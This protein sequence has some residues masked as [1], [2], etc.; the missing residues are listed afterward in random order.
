MKDE[1]DV[2]QIIN[3]NEFKIFDSAL[4]QHNLITILQKGDSKRLTK[5][6]V[7]KRKNQTGT[8]LLQNILSGVDSE[9][10]YLIRANIFDSDLNYIRIPIDSS[11]NLKSDCIFT[12]ILS[13]SVSLGELVNINSG[14]DITISKITQ[15][16]LKKFQH[17]SLEKDE[18]VFVI[19][20]NEKNMLWK[21]L[22]D[23][24]KTFVKRFIKSSDIEKFIHNYSEDFLLYIRWDTDFTLIPNIIKHLIKFRPILEDQAVRYEEPNW[25][26]YSLHRPREQQI[27]DSAEK[28][29]VPYR[30]IDNRFSIS[31]KSVYSSRDVFYITKKDNTKLDIYSLCAVLN[32]KLVFY[33]LHNKGKKKGDTLEL[34]ATPLSQIP[35]KKKLA[36]RYEQLNELTK[37]IIQLKPTGQC[38]E[39]IEKQINAL[40]YKLYDIEFE[41]I[42]YIDKEF[43]MNESEYN[44][45]LL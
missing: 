6:I 30:C 40:V 21:N 44:S 1:T 45:I 3:F 13:D 16:H 22:T 10:D 11:S 24:E 33:W 36:E 34:Y 18:G 28:I 25:K 26:W 32:S 19:N 31:T 37:K 23:F 27:F 39:K 35:I 7:V 42:K 41:D 2:K 4:G 29:I 5:L 12:K 17:I 38:T 15:K 9:T 14:C 8:T 43:D 20:E